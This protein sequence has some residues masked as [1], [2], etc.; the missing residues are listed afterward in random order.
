MRF[1]NPFCDGQTQ[2]G[3]AFRMRTSTRLIAAKKSLKDVMLQ[4]L[5]DSRP[6]VDN[7]Y[8]RGIRGKACRDRDR[9][10]TRRV[11]RAR[12]LDGIVQ[13]IQEHAPDQRLIRNNG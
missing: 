6:V 2:T 5:R 1:R 7:R 8:F 4:L 9:S 12:I 3:A 13:E 11:F 10:A